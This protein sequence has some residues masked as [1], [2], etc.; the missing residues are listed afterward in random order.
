MSENGPSK[1]AHYGRLIFY[2]YWCWRVGGAVPVKNSTGNNCPRK[3]Q[4][5]PR[6]YY[7]YWCEILVAFLP[8]STG[9]G[10]FSVSDIKRS[11]KCF[12]NNRPAAE[13][14]SDRFL[15]FSLPRVGIAFLQKLTPDLF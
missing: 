9:T 10:N 5:F 14:Q 4:R 7:Q 11:M 12:Q 3:C 1:K 2:H 15:R 6:I 8:F 13:V